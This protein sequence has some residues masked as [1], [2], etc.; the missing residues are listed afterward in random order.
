MPSKYTDAQKQE[1][2]GMIKLGDSISFVHFSTGI[3]ERT[4]RSWRN[5]LRQQANCQ[6]AEKTFSAAACRQSGAGAP[7]QDQPGNQDEHEE[8][9]DYDD[10]VYIREQLMK[11]ARQI[12]A[13]LQPDELDS[14]RRILAL[15]R[16]L[17]RIQWLDE[18]LPG[19]IPQQTIRVEHYYDGEVQEHPPWHGISQTEVGKYLT[20]PE[21]LLAAAGENTLLPSTNDDIPNAPAIIRDKESP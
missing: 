6:T 13:D 5:E 10:F 9:D 18:V 16:I 19:R 17:D 12:A 4:L 1:A 11:H 3:P 8:N 2:L 20:S 14:S 7:T 21:Y 15:S